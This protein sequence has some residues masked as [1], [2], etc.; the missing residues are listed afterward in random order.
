MN[1]ARYRSWGIANPLA[2]QAEQPQWSPATLDIAE[3]QTLLP[4]GNGRSYGDSCLNSDGALL[5]TQSLNR[6]IHFDSNT[7]LLEAEPG[8][9]LNDILQQVV[10]Q[11][12]FLPVSPGTSYITLG[13]AVAND[14]HGKNHHCDGTFGRFVKRLQ[15][16]RSNEGCVNCSPSEN[17]ELFC[18]TVGGLG[19]TGLIT[20]VTVQLLQIQS[21]SLDIHM[22]PF[23]GLQEFLSLSQQYRSDFQY[24]VAWLDCASSGKNFGRGIFMA[25]NHAQQ[26]ELVAGPAAP[27]LSIPINFPRWVLNQY[28][29]RAFNEVYYRRQRARTE[30]QQTLHYQSFFYPLDAVGHWNRIYGNRGFHQYQFVVPYE[31]VSVLEQLLHDIVDSGLGS[32]LAVLKEFGE[33]SSPGMLSFPRPGLCLALDFANRGVKTEKLINRLDKQVLE[34]GGAAYPA[35]DRLMSATSFAAYFDRLDT[36]TKFVDPAFSSDFWRRVMPEKVTS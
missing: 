22:K 25:A 36:F 11:G 7:G 19:L 26:G 21:A 31:Q 2:Q 24:T 23:S 32:F 4:F 9:L 10:P 16:L 8:V 34:A 33:I 35:K 17:P 28:S 1:H 6:F 13:G 29:I 20:R 12:W 15:L 18:A 27:K 14:V 5:D 3:C 30:A